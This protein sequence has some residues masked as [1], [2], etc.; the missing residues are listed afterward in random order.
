MKKHLSLLIVLVLCL[1]LAL[2]LTACFSED[3]PPEQ[4]NLP[5]EDGDSDG[6]NSGDPLKGTIDV[7]HDYL[8]LEA[9]HYDL[10]NVDIRVLGVREGVTDVVI[11]E[12]LDGRRVAEVELV[13][14][15]EEALSAM[16]LLSVTFPSTAYTVKVNNWDEI[17]T[18]FTLP[19]GD[20][21]YCTVDGILYNADKTDMV[22]VPRYLKADAVTL[23]DT[24][25]NLSMLA[26]AHNA[27][28]GTLHT[29]NGLTRLPSYVLEGRIGTLIVGSGVKEVSDRVDEYASI[30]R[31]EVVA[32][33]PHLSAYDNVL[34]DK[35]GTEIHS[36][37]HAVRG[38]VRIPDSVQ[39]LDL[40]ALYGAA[41]TLTSLVIPES[42][43]EVR[44]TLAQFSKLAEVYNLSA[45]QIDPCAVTVHDSL[46]DESVIYTDEAGLCYYNRYDTWYLFDYVGTA[47]EVVLPALVRG[48]C[49]ELLLY[50]FY[51]NATPTSVRIE[52]PLVSIPKGAFQYCRRLASVTIPETVRVIGD[53]AFFNTR[54]FDTEL[55]DKLASI[56]SN[57]FNGRYTGEN[58]VVYYIDGWA[59]NYF[60]NHTDETVIL[61]EGTV[62]IA[63]DILPNG[64]VTLGLPD[65]IR[66]LGSNNLDSAKLVYEVYDNGLYLGNWLIDVAD[67]D[68]THLTVREG[69]VGISYYALSYCDSLVEVVIP[70]SV[71]V[72]KWDAFTGDRSLARVRFAEGCERWRIASELNDS[73]PATLIDCPTSEI[74]ADYLAN[75]YNHVTWERADA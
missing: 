49:Y 45:T 60:G 16:P 41:R 22:A 20:G 17:C 75:E 3:A 59:V 13:T 46:T 63:D 5:E 68:I 2:T 28:I 9:T 66:H 33:N 27:E 15:S 50:A 48:E 40:T 10:F 19:E 1:A 18:Y 62:G 71:T 57:A 73:F 34:Y 53:H 8:V 64:L 51:E 23:P 25:R 29:G 43:T 38:H 69:T 4:G 44:G 47:E 67:H 65:S 31:I 55:P 39:L 52:A 24:L 56:G 12:E 30:A 70:A 7:S 11:P 6:G 54:V 72:I 21:N 74:A 14:L 32:D 42:V 36:V 61:R 37:P 26:N 35:E 58:H